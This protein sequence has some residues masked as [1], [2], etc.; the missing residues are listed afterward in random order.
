MLDLLALRSVFGRLAFWLFAIFWIITAL[1][2][3]NQLR[4]ISTW[5]L[6]GTYPF[7]WEFDLLAG[8]ASAC[9]LVYSAAAL[10]GKPSRVVGFLSSRPFVQLGVI[11]YSLYLI[12]DPLLAIMKIGMDKF[13]LGP[14]MQF[15][16]MIVV[17]IP[18]VLAITYPFH[19]IFE[20]PFMSSGRVREAT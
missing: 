8:T 15:G 5:G 1:I 14:F 10:S 19:R 11:S 7:F 17:G 4:F 3:M 6:E 12:H 20:K 2:A 16:A 13:D 9:L 18:I